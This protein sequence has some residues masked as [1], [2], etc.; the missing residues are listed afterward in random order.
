M[1]ESNPMIVLYD[2][3]VGDELVHGEDIVRESVKSDNLVPAFATMQT[4][5]EP[6]EDTVAVNDEGGFFAANLTNG[7]IKKVKDQPGVVDVVPDIEVFA[8]SEFGAGDVDLGDIQDTGQLELDGADAILEQDPFPEWDGEEDMVS[9][10]T[11]RLL[12]QREP[13]IDVDAE[14]A[15]LNGLA[16]SPV[17]GQQWPISKDKVICIVRSVIKCLLTDEN[18]STDDIERRVEAALRDAGVSDS[19]D[20][21]A[22]ADTV[23]WN[24]RMIFAN[25]AWRF[26]TGAGVR[27]AVVDTGIDSAHPDLRVYGGVSYVPGVSPWKD[28]NG[29][30]TH[31]AGTI[32]AV[33]NGRGII[34]V[35]P[36][37][38]LYAVKVLNAAGSGR[39][40]WILNGLTWCYRMRMHVVNLSLGSRE[41]T[42]SPSV[43]N[44]AYE[45][46]GRRLRSRGILAVAAA[47]NSNEPVGN[48]AR[49]PSYMAVSAIDRRRR[50]A[51]FSCFGPQVETAAPGVSIISTIPGGGYRSLSGTSMATPHVAGVAALVKRRWPSWHG[52]RIRVHLWRTAIDL[53][54]SGRDWA[55]GYGQVNA[56][57][58]VVSP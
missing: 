40:S 33:A 58:A 15:A 28:D 42:H 5:F 2:E 53:G 8:L 26:S 46:L 47:G 14:L 25:Y 17:S 27:V 4:D 54:V 39:L 23:L 45:H 24:I 12:S 50:R 13:D 31:V 16:P 30:G 56:W 11:L 18:A 20:A 22:M 41:T 35:A 29:H 10:E 32:A 51:T 34:G 3:K 7:E 48:P 49:C 19:D 9:A 1:A 44:S 38:R 37:A 21:S 57:R 52:D 6:E 43:F 55:F 36:H